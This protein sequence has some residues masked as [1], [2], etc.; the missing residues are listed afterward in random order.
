MV[1]FLSC[2]NRCGRRMEGRVRRGYGFRLW[3]LDA[4]NVNVLIFGFGIGI[5][6]GVSVG[7][8]VGV[9]MGVGIGV[10]SGIRK[11]P[12]SCRAQGIPIGSRRGR[13]D[14]MGWGND[15]GLGWRL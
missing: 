13:G 11:S 3:R 5:G 1:T 14:R 6:A 9:C 8:G 15:I 12:T 10:C 4:D 2:K 7:V